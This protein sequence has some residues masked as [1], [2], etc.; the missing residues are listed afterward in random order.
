MTD[1][2]VLVCR[3]VE[4]VIVIALWV[5]SNKGSTICL[6]SV[7]G[8]LLHIGIVSLWPCGKGVFC[9][10]TSENIVAC[11]DGRRDQKPLRS[12]GARCM[13]YMLLMIMLEGHRE[14]YNNS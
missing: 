2:L 7:S 3:L 9:G 11:C 14:D 1:S 6:L 4:E 8:E 13:S 5:L 12:V 10:W